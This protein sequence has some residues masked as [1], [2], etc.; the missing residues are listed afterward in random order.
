VNVTTDKGAFAYTVVKDGR[1]C[2]PS[3]ISAW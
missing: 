3:R 1:D 2:F